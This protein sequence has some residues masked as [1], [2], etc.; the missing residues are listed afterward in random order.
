[1]FALRCRHIP[2]ITLVSFISSTE[3]ESMCT[4]LLPCGLAQINGRLRCIYRLS[5]RRIF[6]FGVFY[7]FFHLKF[8]VSWFQTR[9]RVSTMSSKHISLTERLLPCPLTYS[10]DPR[11]W[12]NHPVPAVWSVA[13]RM[14]PGLHPLTTEHF[15]TFINR[16]FSLA[17]QKSYA[18]TWKYFIGW[19]NIKCAVKPLSWFV[20]LTN[21][22]TIHQD[23]VFDHTNLKAYHLTRITPVLNGTREHV[24]INS[25]VAEG[26][27]GL[28]G[29]HLLHLS[30]RFRSAFGQ[31]FLGLAL[32]TR[33]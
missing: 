33:T 6:S 9:Y 1:M 22:L 29:Q 31:S 27:S 18:I 4:S 19:A 5:P 12:F 3:N 13:L 23:F 32:S 26:S 30:T 14:L 21:L 20:L 25:G 15:L 7:F 24:F 28:S 10:G 8:V 2:W 16:R 17:T 11:H